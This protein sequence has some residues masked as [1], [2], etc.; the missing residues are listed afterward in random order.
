MRR[1]SFDK[2]FRNDAAVPW[3]SACRLGGMCMS[4]CTLV[5]A[6][7][8]LPSAAFGARLKETVIAGNCPWWLMES[9]S[10]ARSKW[11]NV[12]SGTELLIAELEVVFAEE[13]DPEELVEG[14]RAFVIF[15]SAPELGV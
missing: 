10:E 4:F 11:V 13:L 12:L 8:A 15:D 6:V 3:K 7:I 2:E 5:M 9:G 1:A 14:D